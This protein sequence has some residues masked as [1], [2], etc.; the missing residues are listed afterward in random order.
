MIGTSTPMSCRRVCTSGTAAAASRVLTVT[1][2][3]SLPARWSSATCAAVLSA[4]A[5]SVLVM[6]CTRTG[7][8]PPTMTPPTRTATV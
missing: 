8:P 2:T 6:D 1:R 3:T 7:L 5:V 4:L